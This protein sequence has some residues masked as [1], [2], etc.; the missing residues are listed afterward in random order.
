MEK[1][2]KRRTHM[3]LGVYCVLAVSVAG[4]LTMLIQ[5]CKQ[6]T[7]DDNTTM[8]PDN[9]A[10]AADTNTPDTNV[11]TAPP[12]TPA[13]T[14]VVSVPS[15]IP[16]APVQPIQPVVP[17]TPTEPVS[18]GA[19]YTVL[20]G[21]TLGK[22]AKKNGVTLKALEAANP[23]VQPTKLKLNQKLVIPAG[24]S[25]VT[26]A[27]GSAGVDQV[28]DTGGETYTVKSGDTLSKI[29]KAHG[30]KVKALQSANGLATTKIKVGQKLKIP[31][32]SAVPAAPTEAPAAPTSVYTGPSAPTAPPA[33]PV[34]TVPSAPAP[35]APSAP[36]GNN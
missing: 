25:T 35:S 22:I 32:S 20:K 23:G 30:V 24:G 21:D 15:P 27:P 18:S 19:E 6:K 10:V 29:A 16:Q 11:V 8:T 9:P 5:G 4:L 1:Q 17:I 26:V 14:N 12:V 28:V 34:P 33:P 2:N 3:K 31:S 13:T 7:Q 36:A